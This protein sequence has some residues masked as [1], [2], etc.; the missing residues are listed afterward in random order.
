VLSSVSS[1]ATF[2]HTTIHTHKH[3]LSPWWEDCLVWDC[4]CLCGRKEDICLYSLWQQHGVSNSSTQALLC[5]CLLPHGRRSILM[6]KYSS[7]K[8]Y[9]LF[10][11]HWT[12]SIQTR[13]APPIT[14]LQFP[15]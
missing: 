15:R 11:G 8:Q 6:F 9:G 3:H 4:H 12:D 14:T 10:R 2:L 13:P 5:I 1:S 7:F